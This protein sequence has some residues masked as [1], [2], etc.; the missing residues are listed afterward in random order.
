[1]D[2]TSFYPAQSQ[3]GVDKSLNK[4]TDNLANS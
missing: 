3:E 2:T 1:M 4:L